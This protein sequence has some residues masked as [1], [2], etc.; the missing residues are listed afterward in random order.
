MEQ[1]FCGILGGLLP[2]DI[3]VHPE[4]HGH[5]YH[6]AVRMAS[7]QS[8]MKVP[9][10]MQIKTEV[11]ID[12]NRFYCQLSCAPSED[13]CGGTLSSEPLDC[14]RYGAVLRC[15]NPKELV[16]FTHEGLG[17][18]SVRTSRGTNKFTKMRSSASP[19]A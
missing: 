9:P 5:A 15:F 4:G 13:G 18:R 2:T 1:P 3:S 14:G 10:D 16:H 17:H 7:N 19:T 12:P 11:V 6:K 8:H